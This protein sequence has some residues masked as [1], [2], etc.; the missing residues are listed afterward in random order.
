MNDSKIIDGLVEGILAYLKSKR[1]EYLLDDLARKIQQVSKASHIA[2]VYAPVE[3]NKEQK[4]Q[5]QK[6]IVKLTKD[7]QLSIDYVV[8]R[9]LIDGLKIVYN[10]KV[11]DFSLATQIAQIR[12]FGDNLE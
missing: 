10:D 5:T 12:D 2:K 3:F 11:W 6:L 7:D 4:L 8:D 1:Q 9:K